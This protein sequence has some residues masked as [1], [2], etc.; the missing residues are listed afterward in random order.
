MRIDYTHNKIIADTIT[1][2]F[3]ECCEGSAL[4]ALR[5]RYGDELSAIQ[6]Y[7]DHI[8][9]GFVKRGEFYY[10]LTVVIGGEPQ[11]GGTNACDQCCT[12]CYA[13]MCLNCLFNMCCGC[14]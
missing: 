12:C 11:M 13:N 5:E 6:M 7:E 9:D 2:K 8:N 4:A 10:P 3:T 1:G 14:R